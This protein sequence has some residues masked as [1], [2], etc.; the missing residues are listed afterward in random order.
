MSLRAG[1]RVCIDNDH[2]IIYRVVAVYKM[3]YKPIT[4]A[5]LIHKTDKVFIK[6][7]VDVSRITRIGHH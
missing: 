7:S 2:E 3:A 1:A 6:K 5:L 4:L